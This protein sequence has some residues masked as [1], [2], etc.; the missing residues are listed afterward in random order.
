MNTGYCKDVCLPVSKDEVLCW[1][2]RGIFW[3]KIL[4]KEKK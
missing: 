2:G 4:L 3:L 1:E